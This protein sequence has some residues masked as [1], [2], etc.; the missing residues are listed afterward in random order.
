MTRN[1]GQHR[2]GA[3]SR[4]RIGLRW[5]AAVAF[6]LAGANHFRDPGF[7]LPVI[8]EVLGWP[9][10]WN[11]LVGTAEIAGGVGLL[12]PRLRRAAAAGLVAL[13]AVL[14]WVHVDMVVRPGRSPFGSGTPM[15]VLWARLPFQLVLIAW[16]WWAGG[17]PFHLRTKAP[18]RGPADSEGD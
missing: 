1:R 5:V 7:Y 13:L 17:L 12:T 3:E 10:F 6:V 15:W 8:P 4:G 2:S 14:T 11:A 16:V 9:E 18:T